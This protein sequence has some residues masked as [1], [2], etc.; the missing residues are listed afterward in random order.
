MAVLGRPLAICA[1]CSVSSLLEN[2]TVRQLGKRLLLCPTSLLHSRIVGLKIT[3]YRQR[4]GKQW[5]IRLLGKAREASH[6][7]HSFCDSFNTGV[8]MLRKPRFDVGQ[9]RGCDSGVATA[10]ETALKL[11]TL[12]DRTTA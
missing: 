4:I 10:I 6:S 9:P 3:R 1:V 2:T 5:S 12:T 11:D 7:T 8:K